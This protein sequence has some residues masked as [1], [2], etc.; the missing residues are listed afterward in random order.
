LGANA[1]LTSIEMAE[2]LRPCAAWHNNKEDVLRVLKNH[3]TC[4]QEKKRGHLGL[5]LKP[6]ILP[7]F[8]ENKIAYKKI[9]EV[10]LEVYERASK[11]GVR[12]M[13]TTLLAP[14]G[15]ISLVMDCDTTGIEPDYS[16]Q[17][18][19]TLAGGGTM[20]LVNKSVFKGLKSLGHKEKEIH[21]IIH[22]ANQ[23][24]SFEGAPGLRPEHVAIFDC[25]QKDSRNR[26][27][28]PHSHLLMVAA[29]QPFLCGAVSKT[30]NVPNDFSI[31]Q[32]C[33]LYEKAY[34]LM[35][36][37]VAIFREG[38]KLSWPLGKVSVSQVGILKSTEYVCP[39]CQQKALIPAGS[40]FVCQNCGESTSCA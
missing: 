30:V 31:Q 9:E 39:L 40:C 8:E 1:W 26:Q 5:T 13:Q 35:I 23:T 10:W 27:L 33:E 34:T 38:S 19:K 7:S 22:H 16:F 3:L 6:L 20:G 29:V 17:K 14:T 11:K 18:I 21:P 32:V 36:K 25:A 15:T 2:S 28:S 24:G 4:A 37:A 12:N